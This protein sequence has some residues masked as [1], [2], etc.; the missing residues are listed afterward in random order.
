MPEQFGVE[1]RDHMGGPAD[2]FGFADEP[3]AH[4]LDEV[5]DVGVDRAV[6][7]LRVVG[8]LVLRRHV[9][10]GDAGR[11]EAGEVVVGVEVAVG[12]VTG[13]AG[14]RRPH[15]VADLQIATER[16]DVGAATGRPSAVSPCSDGPSTMKC[17]DTRCGVVDLHARRVGAFGRPDAGRRVRESLVGVGEALAQRE[18]AQPR[19]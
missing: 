13:V 12:G 14:L 15:P 8:R 19:D 6:G 1:R 17:A 7:A 11:L 10:A 5:G 18:L 16:D 3:V 9:A 2:P 4:H